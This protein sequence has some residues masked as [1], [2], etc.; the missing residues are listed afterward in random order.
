MT[1]IGYRTQK[2]KD[3]CI[4]YPSKYPSILQSSELEKYELSGSKLKTA[5]GTGR[6]LDFG[7]DE[8]WGL[9][10]SSYTDCSD[11]VTLEKSSLCLLRAETDTTQEPRTTTKVRTSEVRDVST[12]IRFS[13]SPST[14][15]CLL[16]GPLV[17]GF[18]LLPV[19]KQSKTLHFPSCTW[20][21]MTDEDGHGRST[22]WAICLGP[23]LHFTHTCEFTSGNEITLTQQRDAD[24]SSEG[25]L[26]CVQ[27]LVSV[28]YGKRPNRQSAI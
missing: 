7:G 25:L 26:D 24:F 20:R 22:R 1:Y 18:S 17:L 10:K 9:E 6:R 23:C 19:S 4:K 3:V 5:S 15:F 28:C 16:Q 11:T 2:Q 21:Q 13:S 27:R 12:H 14:H 8:P